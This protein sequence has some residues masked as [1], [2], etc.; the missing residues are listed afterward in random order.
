MFLDFTK[1]HWL[2]VYRNRVPVDLPPPTMRVNTDER[3]NPVDLPADTANYPGYSGKFM[4]K[5]LLAWLAMGFRIPTVQG[6][7]R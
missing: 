1:G 2:S 3:P 6:L 5:L 4:L 7:P